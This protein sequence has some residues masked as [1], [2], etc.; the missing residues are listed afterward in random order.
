MEIFYVE[1]V[2]ES[3][4]VSKEFTSEI[5]AKKYVVD[6]FRENPTLELRLTFPEGEIEVF[7]GDHWTLVF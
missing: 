2:K 5:S 4:G 1:S 6:K 7:N 3:E